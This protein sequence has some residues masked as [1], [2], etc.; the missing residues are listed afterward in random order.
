MYLNTEQKN[1]VLFRDREIIITEKASN[2]L[3]KLCK[4]PITESTI[5]MYL[6]VYAGGKIKKALKTL[7]NEEISQIVEEGVKAEYTLLCGEDEWNHI[8]G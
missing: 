2:G 1:P 7:S 5:G 6:S 4:T 3:Y 8:P